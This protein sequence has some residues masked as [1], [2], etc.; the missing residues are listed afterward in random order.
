MNVNTLYVFIDFLTHN[1]RSPRVSKTQT[2]F[3][4]RQFI[5]L[6]ECIYQQTQI[7]L[8]QFYVE[9]HVTHSV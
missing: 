8:E 2:N 1:L 7:F 4:G 3:L 9:V 5:I 6:T